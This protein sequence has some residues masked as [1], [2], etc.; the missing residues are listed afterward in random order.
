VINLPRELAR[1][2]RT[3][4]RY[5][6]MAQGQ[7]GVWPLLLMRADHDGLTLQS[8]PGE[9]T[10]QYRHPEASGS[11][12][13]A[14]RSNILAEFEKRSAGVVS[15]EEVAVEK[16]LARWDDSGIPQSL[17]LATVKPE[18]VS[19]LPALPKKFVPMPDNFRQA[20]TEAAQTTAPSN[21][22]FA[23]SRIQLCG[24]TGEVVATDGR[25][26]LVQSGFTF[27]W[28]DDVLVPRLPALGLKELSGEQPIEIG[29]TDTHFFVLVG[30][31][32]FVLE[33]DRSSRFPNVSNVIPKPSGHVTRFHIDA[34]DAAFLQATLPKLPGR[35]DDHSPITLD[36]T[37]PPVVR[38]RE[39]E[40]EHITEVVLAH[41]RVSGTPVRIC[42]D[43]HFLLR[44]LKYGVNE[45]V[46]MGAN[47]PVLSRNQGCLYLWMP[48]EGQTTL[49][50]GTNVTQLVSGESETQTAPPT[51][52]R[53]KAPMP[54][55]PPNGRDHEKAPT[56][57]AEQQP[58]RFGMEEI[59][60]EAE[61][62]RNMLQEAGVR[63]TRLLA[64]LKQ[65][66]R[67]SRA[68]MAAMASLR[69]L[70]LDR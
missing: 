19:G 36:L 31:W 4:L 33:I 51:I 20:L 41:S 39:G 10:V 45:L 66:R 63:N 64:A 59:I 53:R 60:A 67:Q 15:L 70:Q 16:G 47:K 68:V 38:A 23:L 42:L 44:T 34:K 57:A 26:L 13:I 49:S 69:H 55:P 65:Q 52:E 28:S 24:K 7:R 58:E 21:V 25:Q 8:Q 11:G 9:V 14:F 6:L 12:T 32:T 35:D 27:P 61:A 37:S 50:P 17:E 22:R 46:V 5:S 43:R 1:R 3:V 2:F 30:R 54:A 62:V 48:L 56:P 18:S 40:Q 29:R